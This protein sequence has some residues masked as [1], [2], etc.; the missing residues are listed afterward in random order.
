C[1]VCAKEFPSTQTLANHCIAHYD[2]RSTTCLTC[3]R[4]NFKDHKMLKRH[5]R[6]CDLNSP[7][8]CIDCHHAFVTRQH[9]INHITVNINPR[10]I[11]CLQCPKLFKDMRAMQ[12]HYLTHAKKNKDINQC[13][14]CGEW[15]SR[16]YIRYMH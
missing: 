15:F 16:Q 9:L 4:D 14:L 10:N 1:T 7:F 13:D 8:Q 2:E 5:S 3:G 11:R 6:P 12:R